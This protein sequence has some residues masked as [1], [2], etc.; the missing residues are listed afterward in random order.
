MSATRVSSTR[1]SVP[2]EQN[3]TIEK[4]S[5]LLI[6]ALSTDLISDNVFPDWL[7]S[8]LENFNIKKKSY[9][10]EKNDNFIVEKHGRHYLN[11]MIKSNIA[12]KMT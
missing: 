5:Q 9:Y 2:S 3:D 11:Q 7:Q 1:P 6:T 8:T 10:K 12:S 4:L